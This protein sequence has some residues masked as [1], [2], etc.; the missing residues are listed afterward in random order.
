MTSLA[1][2]DIML[3]YVARPGSLQ[4]KSGPSIAMEFGPLL[5]G[6]NA[7]PGYGLSWTGIISQRFDWGTIHFNVETNLTRDQHA[8]A[9]LSVILEGPSTWKVRP[10]MELYSDKIWTQAETLSALA[11][12]IWQVQDN[13]SFDAAVRHAVV[14]GHSVNEI[15]AGLTFAFNI[16]EK[17]MDMKP[18]MTFA[19]WGPLLR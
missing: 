16:E 6:I 14:N 7:D 10:V 2:P 4:E 17:K 15:R 19:N 13:L 8:E 12:A 5:P 3:K 18:G 1:A 9:F 11:G